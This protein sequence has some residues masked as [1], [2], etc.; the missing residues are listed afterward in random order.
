M[1][2]S[3]DWPVP[4]KL[5]ARGKRSGCQRRATPPMRTSAAI[6]GGDAWRLDRTLGWRGWVSSGKPGRGQ[7]TRE[8]CERR[9]RK[10][11]DEASQEFHPQETRVRGGKERRPEDP[12]FSG[13]GKE[14]PR[15]QAAGRG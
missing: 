8:E 1:G 4:W 11:R 2:T 13:A 12:S 3:W 6:P 9:G 14:Y 10:G 5:S 7:F 15:L